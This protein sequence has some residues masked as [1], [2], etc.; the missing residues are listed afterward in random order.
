MI[1]GTEAWDGNPGFLG[2]LVYCFARLSGDALTI[3]G[4]VHGHQLSAHRLLLMADSLLRN[5]SPKCSIAVST[6]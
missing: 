1:G 5:S 2:S 6:G 3:D 4:D